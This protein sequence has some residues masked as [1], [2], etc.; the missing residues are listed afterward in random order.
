MTE[1]EWAC[2]TDPGPMLDFLRGRASDRKL[3][4]FAVACCRRVW[5][6]LGDE[7]SRQAVEVSER[8]ADRRASER[9]RAAARVNVSAALGRHADSASWAA[10][11]AASRNVADCVWNASTAS[12]EALTRAAVEA[13]PAGAELVATWDAARAAVAGEQTAYLRDLFGPL[14]FRPARLDPS[15]LAWS[16]ATVV[17]L[18]RAVYEGGRFHDLPILAD[19]LL[20]A[21][22]DEEAVLAHCRSPGP[23]VRGCWV[24]DLILGKE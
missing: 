12:A 4:L 23:H 24:L 18:A 9:E 10:Y 16:G 3:R 19:A 20:D 6:L 11:W 15:A 14:L 7:R 1:E 13:A 5:H 17:R 8:Y 21:G 2:A 22:A